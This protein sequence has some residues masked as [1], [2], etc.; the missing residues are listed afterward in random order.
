MKDFYLLH[1][2]GDDNFDLSRLPH[3]LLNDFRHY[4]LVETCFFLDQAYGWGHS[5]LETHF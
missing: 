3:Q 2:I 4:I 1:L 5:V